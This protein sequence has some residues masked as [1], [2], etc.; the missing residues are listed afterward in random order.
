MSA[1]ALREQT[2]IRNPRPTLFLGLLAGWRTV[3][4]SD[5]AAGWLAAA[6]DHIHTQH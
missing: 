6:Q 3:A 2:A 4:D 5:A 1:C